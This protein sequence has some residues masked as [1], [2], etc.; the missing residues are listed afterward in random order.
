MLDRLYSLLFAP[1]SGPKANR[2]KKKEA[3]RAKDEIL[4]EPGQVSI[5]CK[6]ASCE[7]FILKRYELQHTYDAHITKKQVLTRQEYLLLKIYS[8]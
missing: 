4:E 1:P 2:K 3:A 6:C 5:A 7:L 8:S